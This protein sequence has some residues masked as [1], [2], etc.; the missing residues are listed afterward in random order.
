LLIRHCCA[1]QRVVSAR[2]L[3]SNHIEYIP[4][5]RK[6]RRLAHQTIVSAESASA[7]AITPHRH[8][9]AH[10]CPSYNVFPQDLLKTR[11]H[12]SLHHIVSR[13]YV[14]TTPDYTSII[15]HPPSFLA[16]SRR[17]KADACH[18]AKESAT[19]KTKNDPKT[20]C[21]Q[22]EISPCITGPPSS[23][24]I[25]RLPTYWVKR[26]LHIKNKDTCAH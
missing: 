24:P 11:C 13:P 20:F 21:A 5:A 6:S 18:G 15:P 8:T 25:N 2:I 22:V 23:H 12:R 19:L 1:G 17:V 26:K 3:K 9:R 7:E 4:F 10:Y 16:E 14:R